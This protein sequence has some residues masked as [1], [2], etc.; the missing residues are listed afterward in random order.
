MYLH[1]LLGRLCWVRELQLSLVSDTAMVAA[2][3]SGVVTGAGQE[4]SS[5][6]IWQPSDRHGD[7]V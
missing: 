3:V 5:S 1:N 2:W 4:S 7:P 6:V